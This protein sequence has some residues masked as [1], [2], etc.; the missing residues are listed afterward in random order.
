MDD[1]VRISASWFHATRNYLS[2]RAA[3]PAAQRDSRR[4][5]FFRM[6]QDWR[7]T[8]EHVE[9]D[10]QTFAISQSSLSA[11]SPHKSLAINSPKLRAIPLVLAGL[12]AH[13]PCQ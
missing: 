12:A 7:E 2:R 9:W 1:P 4:L 3:L 13:L 11:E 5:A 8:D 10:I 6:T